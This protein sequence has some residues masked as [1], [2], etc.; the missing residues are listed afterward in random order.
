[1]HK[2]H[3]GRI[4]VV[5]RSARCRRALRHCCLDPP[6]ATSGHR[7][8]NQPLRRP[9]RSHSLSHRHLLLLPPPL[10]LQPPLRR[11]SGRSLSICAMRSTT[12]RTPLR[13]PS[14]HIC[15]HNPPTPSASNPRVPLF[16]LLRRPP[17]RNPNRSIRMLGQVR[18]PRP[19]LGRNRKSV[20][21]RP[22]QRQL[23]RQLRRQLL[24]QPPPLLPP[25]ANQA[26]HPP[27]IHSRSICLRLHSVLRRKKRRSRCCSHQTKA[28]ENS[29]ACTDQTT[30]NDK[31]MI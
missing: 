3:S 1:M 9:S 11:V 5:R 24:R 15:S 27:S 6:N 28:R 7:R 10:L 23:R 16:R 29:R 12:T 26:L 18:P 17:R 31:L 22:H 25:L 21:Q 14:L 19:S 4:A 8:S 13:S 2:K 30:Y 20:T